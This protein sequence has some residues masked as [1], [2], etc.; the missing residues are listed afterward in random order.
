MKPLARLNMKRGDLIQNI[1]ILSG[2]MGELKG[3]MIVNI[4]N[5]KPKGNRI[6]IQ[7]YGQGTEVRAIFVSEKVPGR[8]KGLAQ[9][10]VGSRL[11]GPVKIQQDADQEE[12][13]R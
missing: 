5:L 7:K 10:F 1:L 12:I 2:L 3:D 6:F 4:T 11:V 9:G 13:F 8:W